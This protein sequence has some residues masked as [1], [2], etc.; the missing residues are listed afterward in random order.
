MVR[1]A[2]PAALAGIT[3]IKADLWSFAFAL[4]MIAF[5]LV[6]RSGRSYDPQRRDAALM[7]ARMAGFDERDSTSA[8][9]RSMIMRRR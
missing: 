2:S 7:L 4:G 3:G 9:R 8:R 6:A 5:A 1:S